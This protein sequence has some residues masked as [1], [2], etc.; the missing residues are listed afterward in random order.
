MAAPSKP[1]DTK[2]EDTKVTVPGTGP[3]PDMAPVE[4]ESAS[5]SE[6]YSMSENTKAEMAAG[7]EAIAKGDTRLADEIAAGKKNIGG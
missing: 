7:K 3:K 4:H 1:N 6:P 5:P 2:K